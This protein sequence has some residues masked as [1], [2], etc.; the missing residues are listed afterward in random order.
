MFNLIR[1]DFKDKSKVL[2]SLAVL[3]IIE[4]IYVIFK[5]NG[6]FKMNELLFV[7]MVFMV[8]IFITISFFINLISFR[9]HLSPKPGYMI[10][11][12]NISRKKYILTKIFTFFIESFAIETFAMGT[13]LLELKLLNIDLGIFSLIRNIKGVNN[14]A[15]FIQIFKIISYLS[16]QYLTLI[17]IFMLAITIRRFLLKDIKLKGLITFIFANILFFLRS[18]LYKILDVGF[19]GKFDIGNSSFSTVSTS[20]IFTD[21]LY[22]IVIVYVLIYLIERKLSI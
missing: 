21:I 3:F 19:Y 1:Y 6:N 15:F 5:S 10:F 13:F 9:N 8:L 16:L 20:I 2:L 7:N 4:N 12:A 14:S 11:M 22:L 18:Y 17:T